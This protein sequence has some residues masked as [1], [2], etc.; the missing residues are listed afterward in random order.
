MQKQTLQPLPI[1]SKEGFFEKNKD[2]ILENAS[3]HVKLLMDPENY[4]RGA[5]ETIK[6][7]LLGVKSVSRRAKLEAKLAEWEK[8]LAVASETK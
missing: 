4:A 7:Q 5:I 1:M 3:S 6:S 2:K 8:V